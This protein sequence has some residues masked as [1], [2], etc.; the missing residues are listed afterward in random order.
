MPKYV[1]NT[2]IS[3]L[4]NLK[5]ENPK[6][7]VFGATYKGNV[8]DTRES[9]SK[10]VIDILTEKNIAVST[11]DPHANSFEYPLSSLEESIDNSDC[12][13]VLTDHDEF[14]SF[15]KEDVDEISEKLKNK[16]IVDTK[17]ILD[18]NLWKKAGFKI[19][20]LGNGAW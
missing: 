15:K 3:E 5:I 1:C 19:K 4:S 17:N 11:Y 2:I 8:E 7:T 13:V 12:I 16:I 10:K 14:K 20:L 6:V 18:H 9:P